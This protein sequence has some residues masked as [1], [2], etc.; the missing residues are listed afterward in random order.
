MAYEEMVSLN[1]VIPKSYKE[2]L[3]RYAQHASFSMTDVVKCL[4]SELSVDQYQTIPQQ[5]ES[6]A[7]R[8]HLFIGKSEDRLQVCKHDGNG[9][10]RKTWLFR[11]VVS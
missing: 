6:S 11:K 8:T 4:I 5:I 9:G 3:K 7:I 10:H 1:I 2:K